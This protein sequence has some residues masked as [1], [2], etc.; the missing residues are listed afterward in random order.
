MPKTDCETSS[1]NSD[2]EKTSR[3]RD[4]QNQQARKRLP[5]QAVTDLLPQEVK[6]IFSLEYEDPESAWTLTFENGNHLRCLLDDYDLAFGKAEKHEAVVR[7]RINAIVL[8]TLA[9]KKREE[10]GQ[11][12]ANKQ[13]AKRTSTQNEAE[14]NMVI[15]EAKKYGSGSLRRDQAIAYMGMLH[16]G[17][18]NAG[19]PNTAIYGIATD[20]YDWTFIRLSPEGNLVILTLSWKAGHGKEIISHLHKIMDHAALLSPVPTHTLSRQQTVEELSGLCVG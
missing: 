18:K 20:S 2:N 15:V 16:H 6:D 4:H 8:N 11:H 7:A 12:A 10:F 3:K 19:R 17:R 5:T 14:T 13:P 1:L 9:A